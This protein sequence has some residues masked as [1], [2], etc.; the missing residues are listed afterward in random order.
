MGMS[1]DA[2][3]AYGIAGGLVDDYDWW[4]VEDVECTEHLSDIYE[5]FD[6]VYEGVKQ[7]N[8][9][10]VTIGADDYPANALVWIGEDSKYGLYGSD[11]IYY[12]EYAQTKELNL[13]AM[14]H[15]ALEAGIAVNLAMTWVQNNHPR[16]YDYLK[17]NEQTPAWRVFAKYG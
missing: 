5:I 11:K 16:V 7:F 6:Q 14:Q 9:A 2:F 13:L 8:C 1:A 10:F 12:V 17:A 15:A 4:D 3:V